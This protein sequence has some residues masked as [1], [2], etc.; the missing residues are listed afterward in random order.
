MPGGAVVG[1]D[2]Q[3]KGITLLDIDLSGKTELQVAVFRNIQGRRGGGI[4]RGISDAVL[5][6][7]QVITVTSQV[8]TDTIV[9]VIG[10]PGQVFSM[11]VRPLEFVG[12]TPSQIRLKTIFKKDLVLI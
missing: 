8:C 12:E 3:L 11:W 1:T 10:I 6:L 4:G 2:L 7:I 5:I 9:S